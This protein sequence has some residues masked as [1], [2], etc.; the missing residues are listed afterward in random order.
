MGDI[1]VQNWRDTINDYQN[2]VTIAQDGTFKMVDEIIPGLDSIKLTPYQ[3][4][5]VYTMREM[6]NRRWINLRANDRNVRLY[7]HASRVKEK[8]GAGKTIEFLA[9]CMLQKYPTITPEIRSYDCVARPEKYVGRTSIITIRYDEENILKPTL[10]FVGA[11]VLEQWADTIATLTNEKYFV[12]RTKADMQLLVN[13]ISDRSINKYRF[14]LIKNGKIT[15]GI[16]W[17]DNII[18][19][20]RNKIQSPSMYNILSNIVG[21]TWVRIIMDDLDTVGMPYN[22][23][24]IPSIYLWVGHSTNN[25]RSRNTVHNHQFMRALDVVKYGTYGYF[26]ILRNQTLNAILSVN[27]A[28]K[29]IHDNNGLCPP[30]FFVYIFENPND[31]LIGMIGL[32]SDESSLQIQEMLNNDSFD[33]A[34]A[35]AGIASTSV[36]S[37]FQALLG[38]KYLD[39]KNA[40]KILAFLETIPEDPKE[41]LPMKQNPDPRDKYFSKERLL[42]F[43]FP[44]YNYPNL[45]SL[46]AATTQE[47]QTIFDEAG[48]AVNR[49]RDNIRFGICPVCAM[50]LSAPGIEIF[51][52]TCC[53]A[54]NCPRCARDVLELGKKNIGGEAL[55]STCTRCRR[56]IGFKNLIYVGKDIKKA[57]IAE[58][59]AL[60]LEEIDQEEKEAA[61]K[62]DNEPEEILEENDEVEIEN[63]DEVEEVEEEEKEELDE[64]GKPKPLTKIKAIVNLCLGKPVNVPQEEVKCKID[65]LM[66]GSAKSLPKPKYR[67]VLIFANIHSAFIEMAKALKKSKVKFWILQGNSN[68]LSKIARA[69]N[70]YEGNAAM[71]VF[72]EKVCAGLNLQPTTHLVTYAFIRNLDRLS[73]AIGR[74]QR[75]GR[76]NELQVIFFAYK[77]EYESMK[78]LIFTGK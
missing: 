7:Y 58:K 1:S 10:I 33:K 2:E 17:P 25:M 23:S 26:R 31:G 15:R 69:Y 6:E 70:T 8:V 35:T 47:Y 30:S 9:L 78:N 11:A 40:E 63:E 60:T 12:V 53:G 38:R 52:L 67:K 45:K 27:S 54:V 22:G 48:K 41:R 51:I 39:Y 18:V 32:L 56:K 55:T 61:K 34:A 28:D 75:M 76:M 46:I 21:V 59:Y 57:D 4:T 24:M 16:E 20:N 13:K 42:N 36:A 5:T 74:A 65:G 64:N 50:D 37:I 68:E 14:V 71:I 49:V 77:N 29:F 73:Q 66:G 19:T 72:S 62:K 3:R 43:E 44:E